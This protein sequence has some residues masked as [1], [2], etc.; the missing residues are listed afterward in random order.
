MSL[1]NLIFLL[2]GAGLVWLWPQAKPYMQRL[3]DEAEKDETA[4]K[5]SKSAS[6]AGSA[7]DAASKAT[8]ESD[9]ALALTRRLRELY[10]VAD[11]ELD[12]TAHAREVSANAKFQE[13]RRLLVDKAV[14]LETVRDYAVGT[15]WFFSCAALSALCDRDDGRDA[16]STVLAFFDTLPPWSMYFALKFF[17]TADPRPPVGEPLASASEWWRDNLQIINAFREHFEERHALGDTAEFGNALEGKTPEDRE[18]IKAFLSRMR[19]PLADELINAMDLARRTSLDRDFLGSFGRFWDAKKEDVLVEP[20]NWQEALDAAQAFL[21]GSRARSLLVAGEPRS[22]KTTFLKLLARRA[23]KDGWKVFEAGGADLMAGQQWFGQLEGRI[24]RA[25]D[26]LSTSK[27][28]IWYIPDI[29][30]IAL[31]G[32]HQGQAASILD[33][34]L[35]AIT[36]GRLVVW[37][38]TSDSGMARLL[39]MRPV[40]RGAFEVARIEPMDV[41]ETAELA[42]SFAGAYAKATRTRIEPVAIETA[43]AS[44]RQYLTASALPGAALDLLKL[45]AVRAT[46]EGGHKVGAADI[47]ETL[48]QLT[49]LPESILDGNERVDLGDVRAYFA[50][51]VI[52]QDEAVE[53]IVQRIAM[54]KAGLNDPGKPIGVFLFAGPTGTGKTELAK[55][56]ADY[57]FG[58]QDRM[59]RLDMSEFQTPESTNKILGSGEARSAATGPEDS[60]IT[61]VRKQ[62]F[63]VVLLDEF[64]KAH[65]NVWDMFLQVFDDGRL[66]DQLGQVADFRHCIIILTSN[67]GA[68]THRS[69]GLGF[70]PRADAYASDQ[71]LR[72][73]GQ[74]F[75]PEF[76]NRLDKVIVFQPLS[77]ELMRGILKKELSLIVQRRGLKDREWAV[78]WEASA[79]EF[80]LEKGFSPEMGARPLKRAIDQYLVAP[81]AETIVEKRFPEGDQFVFVRSDGRAIQAEFVDPDL[82]GPSPRISDGEADT[83][84]LPSMILAPEG[85][86]DELAVLEAE[87]QRIIE[88]ITSPAWEARKAELSSRM[89]E[90]EFWSDPKRFDALASL[91]RL[92]R[93][94]A[95]TDTAESL[96]ARLDKGSKKAGKSS[97]Q[98]VSRL[99][100]QVHL[101]NEG[102]RDVEDAAAI[103]LA[104]LVEPV[105]ERQGDADASLAWCRKL[106]DMYR[107]WA[108][109]R[110]MQLTEVSSDMLSANPSLPVLLVS[111][112]GAD[113]VLSAE[114]GLHVFEL[115][116]DS[117]PSRATARVRVAAAPLE[118]LP[119]KKQKQELKRAFEGT[120][121]SNTVL[122]RY[123]DG[124]SP[125]VRD[126]AG[127]WRS[128][129]FDAV[130]GGDFDLIAASRS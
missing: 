121:P 104:L 51:R 35:P 119:A 102:L 79:L 68:T 110:N 54:L 98:L 18:Q 97:R 58:S 126:L 81:L 44:A 29:L 88:T 40:L 49:G 5:D 106:L 63:S 21:S 112:F 38:E 45:S 30:L 15:N 130:L 42:Q 92:D 8:A 87:F 55:T 48:A 43:L 86:D 93:V 66:T 17:C 61:R 9:A 101:V 80:L 37:T 120:F 13:A 10:G 83:L 117:T 20:V 89:A 85:T 123:R 46:K 103:E 125:L 109:N 28:V 3:I 70:A 59:I 129:R 113:R 75:R 84:A 50:S 11:D 62:P 118:D 94:R 107:G 56:L 78:E 127:G 7:G 122:R 12:H 32:T 64:E 76:Q 26:E 53:A 95:A 25:I 34:I 71:V 36:S 124:A 69:A 57:L 111:G 91:A 14:P 105:F 22:G 39:R 73:I 1:T 41:T 47:I 2:L 27:K 65:A 114:Q 116:A 82:D 6:A 115:P 24:Q 60:L 108:R 90:P 96:K 100:L 31:S 33:Q 16:A 67:L 72:A 128:G 4:T 99:A 19:H 74:T 23:K 77:R 52:G